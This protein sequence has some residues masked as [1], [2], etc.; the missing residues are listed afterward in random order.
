M[1]FWRK[2]RVFAV[3]L[4]TFLVFLFLSSSFVGRLLYAIKYEEEI[5]TYAKQYDL[6]PLLVA[7]IIRVET[8]YRP[9]LESK[10]GAYGLMQ[11]MP[12]TSDWIIEKAPFDD[13]YKSRLHDP[14]VSIELG[15][16]YLNWMSK[17]FEGNPYAMVAGYNAGHGKVGMWL[18]DK[19]W[20]G[21]LKNSQQI[22]YGETRHYLQ[23]VMYYYH[24]YVKLYREE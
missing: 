7:A 8:N 2:K 21:T 23:R 6:D 5:H 18:E 9:D 11:L 10:K 13:S 14:A 19:Q 16:W 12:D 15:S 3:L 20:D 4:V 1:K 24:K 17:Q 22:P